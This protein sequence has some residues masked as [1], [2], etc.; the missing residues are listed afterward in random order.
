MRTP[1]PNLNKALSQLQGKLPK[2]AKGKDVKVEGK[3]GKKGY[4]Y[5]YAELA[6]VAAAVG[7]LLAEFGLAFHC[8]PTRDPADKRM[9]ILEWSLLHESGEER[10]G[11]WPLGPANQPPQTLGSAITYGR[12]YTLGAA[13]GVVTEDDDDGQRAQDRHERSAGDAFDQASRQRPDRNSGQQQNDGGQI[14]KVADSLAKAAFQ[15]ACD[16]TKTV[17]D[18][19]RIRKQIA[20]REKL[21]APVRNYFGEGVVQARDVLREAGQRMKADPSEHDSKSQAPGPGSAETAEDAFARRFGESL[22]DVTDPDGIP[23]KLREVS[24]AVKD[25]T[26]SPKTAT[27]LTALANNWRRH[28]QDEQRDQQGNNE[29]AEA[30]EP[31][32]TTAGTGTAEA[33]VA[34]HD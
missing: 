12:R 5:S 19:E 3:E 11:E 22:D 27:D 31:P 17:E 23:A 28:L 15:I 7:P 24:Q 4:S 10:S 26:I 14:D 8:A 1:T 6:D 32:A 25:K 21:D 20:G 2:V 9:M 29:T 16:P 13:T 33:A 30:G 34:S 18:L